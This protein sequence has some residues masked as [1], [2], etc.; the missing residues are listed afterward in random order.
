MADARETVRRWLLRASAYQDDA[1][2]DRDDEDASWAAQWKANRWLG[3]AATL[4]GLALERS[5]V[6]I[7]AIGQEAAEIAS[8]LRGERARG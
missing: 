5:R 2:L 7:E 8:Y 4:H 6:E 1:A 3:W